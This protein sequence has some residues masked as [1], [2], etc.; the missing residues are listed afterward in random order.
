[1]LK[2]RRVACGS[3]LF[4]QIEAPHWDAECAAELE[5]ALQCCVG[6]TRER[7]ARLLNVHVTHADAMIDRF[8]LE[9]ANQRLE[10]THGTGVEE[11]S[12]VDGESIGF[13]PC[14]VR[15]PR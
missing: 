3:R 1:G 2:P 4:F 9:E 15:F 7:C 10:V 5:R 6:N 13:R 8:W 12:S 11:P 14:W